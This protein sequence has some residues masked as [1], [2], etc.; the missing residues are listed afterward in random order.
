MLVLDEGPKTCL[1]PQ[2]T[3]SD[4]ILARGTCVHSVVCN[5]FGLTSR[6]IGTGAIMSVL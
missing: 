3:D 6:A 4:W 5:T 2:S 1:L